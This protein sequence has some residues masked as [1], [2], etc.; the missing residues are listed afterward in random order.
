MKYFSLM[1]LL[2]IF[3]CNHQNDGNSVVAQ[4]STKNTFNY[5]GMTGEILIN[6]ISS[7]E[8]PA[9]KNSTISLN[10]TEIFKEENSIH[11]YAFFPGYPDMLIINEDSSYINGN[12]CAGTFRAIVFSGPQKPFIS[13]SFGNCNAPSISHDIDSLTLTFERFNDGGK[14]IV[15]INHEGFNIKKY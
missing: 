10:K 9:G 14:Q 3:G 11:P 2:L 7:T 4:N 15:T 1:L 12:R 5:T 6:S 13:D 8:D